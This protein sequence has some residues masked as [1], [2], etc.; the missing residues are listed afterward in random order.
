MQIAI[1]SLFPTMISG[2]FAESIIKRAQEKG[3]VTIHFVNPREFA[4]DSYG[5]VDDKPY[6]GGAGMVFRMEPLVQSLQK[7]SKTLPA[8]SSNH[9]VLTSPRGKT[10]DQQKAIEFSKRENLTIIAGHYEAMDERITAHV[11]EEISLGDFVLT[12]GELVAATIVDAVVR[13]LPGV[14]KKTESTEGES[15]FTVPLPELV[16][17]VGTDELLNKLQSDGVESVQLLEYPQYTRPE[18]FQGV[19]VPEVLLSGNHQEID[20]WRLQEAYKE[21]VKRRYDLL[22]KN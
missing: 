1:I 12:G 21:T 13:L 20:K 7:V 14:L 8:G 5:T 18:E 6:G 22:D 10:F 3:L 19:R 15:F 4:L 2:F 17:A 9:V 11:D 16:K